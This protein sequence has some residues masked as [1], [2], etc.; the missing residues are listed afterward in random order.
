MLPVLF[1]TGGNCLWLP[2]LLS[3]KSLY[4]GPFYNFF[5]DCSIIF[6]RFT[7]VVLKVEMTDC[8]SYIVNLSISQLA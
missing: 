2:Q 4:I 6:C 3:S 1:G 8:V 7:L 5:V